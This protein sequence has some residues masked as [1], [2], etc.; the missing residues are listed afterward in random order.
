VT[1]AQIRAALKRLLSRPKGTRIRRL[2]R[3]GA[4]L[5]FRAPESGRIA[6]AWYR[7]P[8]GAHVAKAKPLLIAA[9]S[10]HAP[11]ARTV[12]VRM[13]VT[14]KGRA[15]L[16]R[17]RRIKLTAKATFTPSGGQAVSVI[18]HFKLAR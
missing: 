3:S 15:L 12:A 8:K 1:V 18:G 4:K 13:K 9:G 11:G 14:R 10:A 16:R 17:A 6:V 7:V 2:L 5:R